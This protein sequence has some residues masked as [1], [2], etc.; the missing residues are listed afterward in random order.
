MGEKG[1]YRKQTTP[2]YYFGVANEFGLCDMHGNVWEWCEDDWHGKYE[3]APTDGSAW[4][5]AKNKESNKTSYPLRGGSWFVNPLDC[6]SAYRFYDL[7]VNRDS[8][9]GFRVIS[10]A[11]GLT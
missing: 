6:R 7:I 10:F 8:N 11:P 4:I 3:G 2:V 1:E 5:D 9:L